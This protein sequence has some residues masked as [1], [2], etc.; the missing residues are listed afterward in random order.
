MFVNGQRVVCINDTFPPNISALY[1]ELPVKDRE[2][3]IRDLYP[4]NTFGGEPEV[5]VRLAGMYNPPPP[6]W[7]CKD[8]LGFSAD[9]FAPLEPSAVQEKANEQRDLVPG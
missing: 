7:N 9:R 2:Y 1:R 6:H 4:A 8:E 5:G 3:I